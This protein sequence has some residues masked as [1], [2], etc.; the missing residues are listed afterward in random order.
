MYSDKVMDHFKN[1]RN[2]GEM[3]NADG[4][5][6]VGNPVCGDIMKIFLKIE[7]NIVTDAKFKTFGCG[8]AIA[9]SSM[10]T[11]LVRGKT[12]RRGLGR[13]QQGGGRG[14]RRTPADQDALLGACRGRHPQGDQRLPEETRLP[15]WE[16]KNPHSHEHEEDL[17][18][19][20]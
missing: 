14:A 11:E 17:T 13:L 10:A 16:E 19:Q 4:I 15:E 7:N 5:G 3:E 18:C 2:V 1:P 20:H 12:P 9:S 6:E 8:A